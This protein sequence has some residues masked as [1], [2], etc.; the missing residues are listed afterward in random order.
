MSLD[1]DNT[2]VGYRLGR[3]FAVLEK[4]QEEA[5][6]GLNATI[7]D[8]FYAS[9]SSTP[10]A[11]YGNLMRLKNHHLGKLS[12]GRSIYFEKLLGEVISEIPS[13][14]AHL[15]L[16]DQGGFAIG[17]YHQRQDFFTGKQTKSDSDGATNGV[18]GSVQTE[19]SL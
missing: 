8:K 2:N 9:A 13:F 4:I 15:S 19:S 10:N 11:V 17:Y 6:P 5:N 1:K 12:Q 16:D 7:R 3:L 18:G 14:P